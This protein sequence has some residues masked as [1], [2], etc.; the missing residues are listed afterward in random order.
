MQDYLA[1]IKH[2]DSLSVCFYID[3]DKPFAI[4]D[5]MH[6]LHEGAYM[7]GYNWEA[8]FNYYLAKN[9][10][11]IIENMQTDPE[12][13]MYVAY[14]D[15]TAD[16]EEKARQLVEVIEDLI[17]NEEKLYQIIKENGDKIEWD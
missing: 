11:D 16:N 7:N 15:L 1:V 14:Y 17:E 10:P 9:N 3:N 5:K 8:F 6:E 2:E 4:G 13:S 12:A